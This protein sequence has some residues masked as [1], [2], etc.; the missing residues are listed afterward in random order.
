LTSIAAAL[1][2]DGFRRPDGT[3]WHRASVAR[4]ITDSVYPHLWKDTAAD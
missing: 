2:G 4:V 3:R 1:N